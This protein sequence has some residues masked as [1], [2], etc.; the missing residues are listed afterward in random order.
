ME[1]PIPTFREFLR[2]VFSEWGSAVT[3]GLTAPLFL[4]AILSSGAPRVVLVATAIVCVYVAWYRVWKRERQRLN[5]AE[6]DRNRLKAE[7]G[8]EADMQGT[9]WVTLFAQPV[10]VEQ[11]LATQLRITVNAA[12]HGRKTCEIS[13]LRVVITAPTFTSN[14]VMPFLQRAAVQQVE[15]GR[16]F[17][18]Q[19]DYSLVDIKLTQ[20]EGAEINV[21]L[22]DSLGVEYKKTTTKVVSM[23]PSVAAVL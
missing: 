20:L 18:H 22:V 2:E 14:E 12:N 23:V 3:G 13:G 15:Y 9:I 16:T 21:F 17:L 10:L 8:A 19:C 7:L 11:R 4:W 1:A 5:T 6:S